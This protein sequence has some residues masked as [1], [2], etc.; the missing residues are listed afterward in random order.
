M[1]IAQSLKILNKPISELAMLPQETIMTMAQ[2]GQIPVAFVA[3]I[4]AQKAETDQAAADAAAIAAQE[5]MPPGSVIEKIMAQ[6]AANEARQAMPMM[7]AAPVMPPM[8]Q[9][10]PMGLPEEMG[11]GALPVSE[12]IMPGY[13]GG[14][15]I[16]FQN[17][18]LVEDEFDYGA[19][20][21]GIDAASGRNEST[22]AGI[23]S[24]LGEDAAAIKAAREAFLGPNT[25]VADLLE[26]NKAAEARAEKL[27]RQQRNFR[28]TQAGLLGLGGDSPYFGVNLGKMAPAVEGAAQDTEKREAAAEAR[29][30]SEITA[31]GLAR[32]EQEKTFTEALEARS[33]MQAA[34]IAANKPTDMRAY[35]RDTELAA[36][37]DPA[38]A[39]RVAAVEKYLPMVGTS[40]VRAEAA[41]Q[42]AQTAAA[43]AQ[44]TIQ[45]RAR[46]NVDNGLSKNPFSKE[47]ETIDKLD[48]ADRKAN[49]ESGAKPGDPNYVDSVTPFKDQL[50]AKEEA[51]LRAGQGEGK[52]APKTEPGAKPAA[53]KPTT[54]L[55]PGAKQIGTSNGK[56]VYRLPDG[57]RMIQQ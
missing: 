44:A 43:S 40:G 8:N 15:I 6:N 12:D 57:S 28:L 29:R 36:M 14:G 33:K 27:A 9:G 7:A 1:S 46:D 45:D 56:P 42:Q 52:P 41:V 19:A 49:K 47:N 5:Q 20:T 54:A 50:Y 11:I 55:P 39:R 30:K 2:A 16:A 23:Y 35:V 13:A 10:M 26:F 38:A 4:L 25:S 48:R 3:P 53:A 17:R 31:K 21:R 24:G 34:N 37:G 22:Y 18:G 32:A 51:R